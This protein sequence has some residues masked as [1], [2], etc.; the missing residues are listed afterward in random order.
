MGVEGS[1]EVLEEVDSDE[2]PVSSWGDSFDDGDTEGWKLL[3]ETQT[4]LHKDMTTGWKGAQRRLEA[5][6]KLL[7]QGP[8][9][10][11]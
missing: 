5:G 1:Q 7:M 3:A 2:S 6:G 8:L 9:G 10:K 4:R 11:F